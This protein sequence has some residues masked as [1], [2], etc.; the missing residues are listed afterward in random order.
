M[1]PPLKVNVTEFA[2]IGAKI[3]KGA[4]RV[5]L[6]FSVRVRVRVRA[7]TFS[8]VCVGVG[9]DV[10]VRTCVLDPTSIRTLS[11]LTYSLFLLHHLLLAP[12]SWIT[13]D[14]H[15][16]TRCPSTYGNTPQAWSHKTTC[17]RCTQTCGIVKVGDNSVPLLSDNAVPALP[18]ED[19]PQTLVGHPLSR[20]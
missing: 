17:L 15:I 1:L 14:Q 4:W 19:V 20:R 11:L 5:R 7:Y 3:E 10:G 12:S 16:V 13:L 18:P 2:D 8:A 9:V 6:R